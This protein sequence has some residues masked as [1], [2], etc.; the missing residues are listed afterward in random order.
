MRVAL[1]ALWLKWRCDIAVVSQFKQFQ[2]S[3]LSW[4][5][6]WY[7]NK[8]YFV[9]CSLKCF[10]ENGVSGISEFFQSLEKLLTGQEPALHKKSLFGEFCGRYNVCKL[11]VVIY[12]HIFLCYT[13][14]MSSFWERLLKSHSSQ[15]FFLRKLML[16]LISN[17][18]KL[19]LLVDIQRTWALRL[20]TK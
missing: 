18:F 20:V 17:G 10:V 4:P 6:T 1:T 11:L 16:L 2:G 12:N 15:I 13:L 5:V 9:S 7:I 19:V 14:Y 8:Y 3:L